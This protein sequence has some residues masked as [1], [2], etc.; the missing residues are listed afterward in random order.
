VA[1]QRSV[2]HMLTRARQSIRLLSVK[3]LL[4]N[5][6]SDEPSSDKPFDETIYQ[7]FAY[8]TSRASPPTDDNVEIRWKR[9]SELFMQKQEMP[10]T[11]HS[12]RS[13]PVTVDLT[14]AWNKLHRILRANNVKKELAERQ[15]YEKPGDKRRRLKSE[16]WRR[17]FAQEV[18][19]KVQLVH[20]IKRRGA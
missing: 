15:R 8:I 17:R 4:E 13:V 9:Q 7:K 10:R 16:R 18:R 20:E 19:R 3:P 6:P 5:I 1:P 12:G 11:P 14:V 2:L